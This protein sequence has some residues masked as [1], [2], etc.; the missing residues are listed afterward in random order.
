MH[1]RGAVGDGKARSDTSNAAVLNQQKG[2]PRQKQTLQHTTRNP[3]KRPPVAVLVTACVIGVVVGMSVGYS[4]WA[5]DDSNNRN[6]TDSSVF[7]LITQLAPGLNVSNSSLIGNISSLVELLGLS[8]GN[9]SKGVQPK[10]TDGYHVH[11]PV[12]M[13]PGLCCSGLELWQGKS[14]A[15]STFRQRMWGTVSMMHQFVLQTSCW[16][17][18]MTLDPSSGE[19][20]DPPGIKL[21]P[22]T[23][24]AASDYVVPGYWVWAPLIEHLATVG[25]DTNTMF[26]FAY[27]WRLHFENVEKRDHGFSRLKS[28]VEMLQSTN[29][30]HK[31]VLI[32]HSMGANILLHFLKWVES[33]LGGRGGPTWVNDHVQSVVA[34]GPPWLGSPKVIPPILSGEMS[35]A[36][37]ILGPLTVMFD[38]FFSKQQ[39]M[40]LFRSWGSL[41]SLLPRGGNTIWGNEKL[42]AD[43]PAVILNSTLGKIIRYDHN[44]SYL[45][46]DDLIKWIDTDPVL[47]H[48]TSR[49]SYGASVTAEDDPHKWS[50]PL[51]S[52]LPNANNLTIYCLYGVG[53]GT[54]RAY[55]YTPGRGTERTS[56]NLGVNL[57]KADISA[58]V[59]STDGDGTVPLIS[60]GYMCVEAWPNNPKLNPGGVQTVTKEY[61]HLPATLSLRGGKD[62]GD[63]VDIMGNS[64]LMDDVLHIVS[65][66]G[67]KVET[68]ILSNIKEMSKKIPL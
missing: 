9:S 43:D 27:D 31:V 10:L 48:I 5:M 12:V 15:A 46:M 53:K 8:N 38:K 17:E 58:G 37:R 45:L 57:P 13:I 20:I 34:I 42:S 1:K 24:M 64:H 29:E 11:H 65:G 3:D 49:Y 61:K 28:E 55:H 32:T 7:R 40:Q 41:G 14:C 36:T 16:A 2:T 44:G 62:T 35:E 51:E 26:M 25:Y 39:R 22:S 47:H 19:E 21:R 18:H 23:G 56:L 54:E 67:N 66:Q 30:D 59:Q 52:P 63:H 50:N 68:T 6:A 60:L 33:P 4:V